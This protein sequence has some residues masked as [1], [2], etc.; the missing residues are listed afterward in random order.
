MKNRDA[1]HSE[2]KRVF[3]Y[4]RPYRGRF[5]FI[6]ALTLLSTLLG[7]S[8]PYITKLLIDDALLRGSM[9][10]LVTVAILMV[11]VTA[12]GFAISMLTSYR[13][14]S[15]SARILFD[16]RLSAYRHLQR[17]SP[18]FYTRMKIGDIVSRL[19]SDIGEIQR[20]ASDTLLSTANN[21]ITLVGSIIIMLALDVKLFAVSVILLPFSVLTIKYF[22]GKLS[23]QAMNLRKQS[24]GIGSFLVETLIG[25]RLVVASNAQGRE[26][27]RFQT[28]NRGFVEA[29]L[30]MQ[31]TSYLAGALPGTLLSISTAAVFLYGGSLVIR[32]ALSIGALIA[33]MAYHMRLMAP[34]QGFMGLYS[35]IATARASLS[36]V[37]EIIDAPVEVEETANSRLIGE[38]RG[39]IE[40]KDVT[41]MSGREMIV[42]DSASFRLP[43]GKLSAVAGASG[44]GKSTIVDLLVRFYDPLT[45]VVELDGHGLRDLRLQDLRQAIALVEQE[46]VLFN[47]TIEENI[48]YGHPEATH[49]QVVEAAKAASLD[50]FIDKLPDKYQTQVGERG[51][52]LSA[53]ERQRL[54]IARAVIRDPAIIVL[55]EPT[56]S[57]D[58]LN[59]QRIGAA[60]LRILKDRTIVVVSHRLSLIR[61]CDHVVVLDK[62]KVAE[63]GSPSELLQQ[64]GALA[65]LFGEA[66]AA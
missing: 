6:V 1:K 65:R 22:S 41:Y 54:A 56:A 18:G 62:G 7:L 8:Q 42:L 24:A 10:S 5:S 32:G 64:G 40:F 50:D 45:G 53:G 58:P 49:Q 4:I 43:A 23:G 59:E 26:A 35:N 27:E 21:A 55:D 57:L 38:L 11:A 52:A 48:K 33:F 47:A 37:F 44:V 14:V 51:Q 19:N 36:R 2:Y 39:E 29:L 16:M 3:S 13:Y 46:P 60:L 12:A 25:M 9:R 20:V 63:T 28:A 15:L 30:S 61:L 34:I 17:L 31:L 66:T